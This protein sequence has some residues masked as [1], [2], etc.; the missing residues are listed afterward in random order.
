[1]NALIVATLLS[2]SPAPT[3]ITLQQAREE[4][5]QSTTALTALQDLE[6]SQQDVNIRRSALLPQLS[7]N[8]FVGKR[9]LGR[10]Q[11]FDLVPDVNNPGEFVQISVESKPTSTGDY[12]LGAVLSQSVY[13]RALW[14]Q[15]EQAGVLRDAQASQAKEEAD[16]AELEA[17]R[18]FFTLFRTQAT[19]QV[20]DATVKRSEEQLE[21]A[22]SLFLAGRVG[23]VEEISALVNLG[24][25]RISFVQSLSQLVTDQGQLAVWLTRPGTQPVEAVDPGVLQS[26]PGPAPTIEQAISV[27]RE[28]RPLLKALEARVSAAEL[29][30]AIARADYI[31]KLSAQGLYTRQGPDAGQVFTEPRLQNNVIARLNLDW[32]IFNGF[33]TPAQTKR[34]EANIRKAQLQLAQSAREIEAEVRTAHQSLEAQIVAARLAA[35]NR[36]AAVQ[37]LNLAE[38]RF[39]AGAGSTLEVRDAQLSLT[40]AELS[41]LENRIDVEIARFTLMRAMGALMSPGETK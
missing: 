12:D 21:R 20:L 17:I 26:E 27:A 5:R 41:L 19:R 34:A 16:T 24:N 2:A 8:G 10:R 40:Q 30:R 32:N 38:E 25:D 9:W 13:D 39:K 29:E 22:R 23:K 11:Q 15:L 28:Q 7:I 35:E 1:M 18:R 14:K 37:G 31:P 3:P 4:G 36:E 6:V 33:I